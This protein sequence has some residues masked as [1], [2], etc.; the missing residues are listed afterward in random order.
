[1]VLSLHCSLI[2]CCRHLPF[3]LPI[4]FLPVM[5]NFIEWGSIQNFRLVILERSLTNS[6]LIWA[7]FGCFQGHC[8]L[9]FHF[10]FLRNVLSII[11]A[12]HKVPRIHWSNSRIFIS[13]VS[14]L[15]IVRYFAHCSQISRQ[16]DF[17]LGPKPRCRVPAVFMTWVQRFELIGMNFSPGHF[18]PVF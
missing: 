8:R 18:R 15:L 13:F 17:F 6:E 9:A 12:P 16:L 14:Y 2:Q 7:S 3:F 5:C 1:M 4:Y 10:F 11:A